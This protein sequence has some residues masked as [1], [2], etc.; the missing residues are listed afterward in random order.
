MWPWP[1]GAP[2]PAVNVKNCYIASVLPSTARPFICYFTVMTSNNEAVSCKIPRNDNIAKTMKSNAKQFTVTRELLTAVA[3][4]QRWPDVLS[5][6]S[7]RLFQNLL[8]LCF[9]TCV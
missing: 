1:L 2:T 5:L 4:D 3:C 6:E 8:L 7:Q 9:A